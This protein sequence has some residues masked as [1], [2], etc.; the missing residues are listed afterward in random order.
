MT[1]HEHWEE[2]A[3]GH[4]LSAL[5]PDEESAF[6]AH[7]DSCA[8]CQAV[9]ADHAFVAAQ[10]G[11]LVD[12]VE[13]PAWDR[14][15]PAVIPAPE[16]VAEV[17]ELATRRRRSPA[18]L[19]AAAAA[20]LAVA[21]TVVAL[22]GGSG[23]GTQQQALDG[24]AAS[25]GCHVVLLADA[26]KLVVD[27]NGARMLPTHMA[28]APAGKVYVLWQLPRDGRPTM[29]ATLEDTANGEVGEAHSLPL[30]YGQT[31]A[32]GVSLEPANVVPTTPTKVLAVGTA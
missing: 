3:A 25:P 12:S 15:R 14:I 32:F 18:L 11:T 10:L 30:D 5:E 26:A 16:P 6:V 27:G 22:S 21:G 28:P 20:V 8:R 19:G 17:V 2:L 4:A 31:A 29:V 9:L 24:C 23:P 7:L 13:A 1:D